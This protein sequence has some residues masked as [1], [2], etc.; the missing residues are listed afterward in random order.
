MNPTK[1]TGRAI[2]MLVLVQL[3]GLTV[4]FILLRAGTS[5]DFLR[6]A[7][8]IAGQIKL[9]VFLLFANAVLTI[10]ISL[11]AYP[12]IRRY[13]ERMAL[14]LLA[15]SVIW[16]AVQAVDNAHIL[17]MLSLSER[18]ATG[19]RSSAELLTT[20][21][22]ALGATRRWLHYTELLVIDTWFLALYGILFRVV[23]VPRL[24]AGFGMVMAAVHTAAIPLP[25]LLGYESVPMLAISLAASH[26]ALA[27][28]LMVKGMR[29]PPRSAVRAPTAIESGLADSS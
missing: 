1:S 7:A 2:G 29:E 20:L 26:L 9:A 25:V 17:S 10:G 6:S 19:E 13:S 24:L 18:F 5:P 15:L 16:L 21:A 3:V 8:P 27:G 28:W 11:V 12:V 23:L 14:G 22:A 4:P